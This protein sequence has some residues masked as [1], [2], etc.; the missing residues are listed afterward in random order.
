MVMRGADEA[1]HWLMLFLVNS[2]RRRRLS[3]LVGVRDVTAGSTAAVKN[4]TRRAVA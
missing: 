4:C 1:V 2:R 3:S